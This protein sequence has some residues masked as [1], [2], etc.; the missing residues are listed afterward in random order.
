MAKKEISDSLK[1]KKIAQA[2][3][4]S[5]MVVKRALGD[6]R[7]ISSESKKKV[8]TVA[9]ELGFTIS[10]PSCDVAIILPS[11]P[12][13]FWLKF[14]KCIE[15]YAKELKLKYRFFSYTSVKDYQDIFHCIEK[16]ENSE[17]KVYIIVGQKHP[18]IIE[19]ITELAKRKHVILL[20]E[21][22]EIENTCYV[23]ENLFQS[24]YELAELYFKL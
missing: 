9:E 7:N 4:V 21:Y 13:Y 6:Y 8:L 12:E 24:G 15:K 3:G 1:I 2:A 16:A 22:I 17:A 23:G 10:T 5:E 20:E 14:S 11:T 19:K 18:T